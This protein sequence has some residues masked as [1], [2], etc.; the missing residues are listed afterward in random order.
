MLAGV[1]NALREQTQGRI[2]SG[3]IGRE[4]ADLVLGKP[5]SSWVGVGEL[6][7]DH[8]IQCLT[9]KPYHPKPNSRRKVGGDFNKNIKMGQIR[10]SVEKTHGF[11]VIKK[12]KSVL[13]NLVSWLGSFRDQNEMQLRNIPALIIDDEAD[14]ASVNSEEKDNPKTINRLV[15]ALTALFENPPF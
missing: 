11:F 10:E 15:R 7:Q 9:S 14:N 3:V 2:D 5:S 6:D 8:P 1:H 13:E 4:S 12:N